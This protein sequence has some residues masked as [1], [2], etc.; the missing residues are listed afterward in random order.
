MNPA[1]HMILAAA[2]CCM[3]PAFA[4][5]LFFAGDSTLDDYRRKPHPPYASWGTELERHMK[6]G[7]KVDNH[8]RSG[9]SSKSFVE[10]GYWT[11]MLARVQPGDF[12]VIQF[13]H[14]DQKHSNEFYR[15]KRF[16]SVNGTYEEHYTR[17][18]KDVRAKGATPMFA[19]SIV[20]GTFDKAGKKL[21]DGKDRKYGTNLRSY[22]EAAIA[23]GK[24]LNVDVVDMNALTHDLLEKVGKDESM[25]FFV[26]STGLVKGKDGEPSKD[27][28]HPIKAGAEAFAKLFLDD[29]KARGLPVADL[30]R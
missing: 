2:I 11:N 21:V 24:K 26:I 9:A 30:F 16:T 15:T 17:F 3:A 28:T 14:N 27:T 8:A 5:T 1:R 12:V 6:D 29:V 22:A 19:T 4:T 20:R 13:G 18:V 25:K 23:L 7:N 10:A